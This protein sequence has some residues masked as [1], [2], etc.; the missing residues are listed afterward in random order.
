[1]TKTIYNSYKMNKSQL[2][3]QIKSFGNPDNLKWSSKI[4]TMFESV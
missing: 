4:P 1:M 2:W 3:S